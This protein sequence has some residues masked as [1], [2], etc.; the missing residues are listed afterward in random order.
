MPKIHEFNYL[1]YSYSN[2]KNN[3]VNKN[4]LDTAIK[5]IELYADY[6]DYNNIKIRRE[7]I[8]M[9]ISYYNFKESGKILPKI[10]KNNM[11]KKRRFLI[12]FL[13]YEKHI[14][15]DYIKNIKGYYDE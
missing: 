14:I 4:T 3:K 8:N 13:G 12:L 9:I 15:N 5:T 11:V 1:D 7:R 10:S 6:C 2:L